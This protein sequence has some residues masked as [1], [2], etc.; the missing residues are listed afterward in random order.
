MSVFKKKVG[1][2]AGELPKNWRPSQYL[3][4]EPVG[5]PTYRYMYDAYSGDTIPSTARMVA[6]YP[7]WTAAMWAR[8]EKD[9]YGPGV[10]VVQ[11]H[12]MNRGDVLDV[13]PG[14]EWPITSKIADWI[15]MRKHA[16]YY[17]PTIYASASN[18]SAIRVA[19]G[20]WE[21]GKDYS[22]W[23]AEWT[24]SP[25]NAYAGS[26]ATQY[27]SNNSFDVSYVYDA[28][29]PHRTAP[30][31][32]PT[33]K[34]SLKRHVATGTVS[35]ESAA[36]LYK[37]TPYALVQASLAH[38]TTMHKDALL[39]YLTQGNGPADVMPKGLVYWTD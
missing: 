4:L 31:P 30:K 2:H 11:N 10:L 36:S 35:L 3:N 9:Q 34:P 22:L 21:L 27:T 8:F 12:T 13:E 7:W 19:T 1:L 17:R 16:G 20:K 38:E 29:W 24:G 6:G 26:S 25:H 28:G 23:V 14:C 32:S 39:A 5:S 18:I 33:P 37:V 15:S